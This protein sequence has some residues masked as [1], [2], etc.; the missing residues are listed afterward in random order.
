MT[1][2]FY[3]CEKQE[4]LEAHPDATPDEIMAAFIEI[5]KRLDL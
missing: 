4:W 5:A 2:Q 3:E 1:Y